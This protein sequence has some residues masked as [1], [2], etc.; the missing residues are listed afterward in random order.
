MN[1]LEKARYV[2]EQTNRIRDV[3]LSRLG[4]LPEAWGRAELAALITDLA[5]EEDEGLESEARR[6]EY[7][8]I[9][10]HNPLFRSLK[11]PSPDMRVGTF[12]AGRT[13][14]GVV[15]DEDE[16]LVSLD[17]VPEGMISNERVFI[18]SHTPPLVIPVSG[19]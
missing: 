3:I 17:R 14:C 16:P 13:A 9:V 12:V 19:K 15:F 18:T 7:Q 5:K 2:V 4:D 1:S 11:K 8:E 10:L 6:R